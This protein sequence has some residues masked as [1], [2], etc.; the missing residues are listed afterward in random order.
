VEGDVVGFVVNRKV[1]HSYFPCAVSSAVITFIALVRNTSKQIVDLS[2]NFVSD[3]R[4]TAL[5]GL[6]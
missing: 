6:R 1:V 2:M 3:F 4:Q 5:G